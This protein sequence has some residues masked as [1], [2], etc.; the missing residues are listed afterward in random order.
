MCGFV[1]VL[2]FERRRPHARERESLLR[3]MGRRIAHRGPDDEQ[4]HDDGCLSLLFRRL[5]IVDVAGGAQPIWNEQRTLCVVVNGEVYNHLDLRATLRE[6]H[7]FQSR[8]DSEIV[9]HLFEELGVD[10]FERLEGMYA[11]AVWDVTRRR[12]VLARDRF[13]IKPLYYH[14]A[15]G[16][17]LFGSELKALLAHPDCPRELEWA[18]LWWFDFVEFSFPEVPTFVK[19]VHYLPGACYLSLAAGQAPEVRPYWSLADH[20]GSDEAPAPAAEYAERYSHAFQESVK[21]HLMS[22]VPAGV[23]LSGGVDSSMIAA[24]AARHARNAHCFTIVTEATRASGDA[25]QAVAVARALGLPVHPVDMSQEALEKS[26][27]YTLEAFESLIWSCD[28]PLYENEFLLKQQLHRH[29]RTVVPGLKVILLGQGAD[30][31]AGGYSNLIR[32][33][34]ATWPEYVDDLGRKREVQAVRVAIGRGDLVA[35]ILSREA[36]HALIPRP[37][38]PFHQEMLDRQLGLQACQLWHEDRTSMSQSIEARVPFL[39]HPLVELLA[40]VPPRLQA[41]LFWDKRIVRQA[42]AAVL[43]RPSFARRPKVPFD[44]TAR[45]DGLEH[46]MKWRLATRVFPA[47]REAYLE[48]PGSLLDRAPMLRLASYLALGEAYPAR[49]IRRQ[50]RLIFQGMALAV[51]ERF[52]REASAPTAPLHSPSPLRELAPGQPAAGRPTAR[53]PARRGG[54]RP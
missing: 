11:L 32:G 52:C 31:F 47:F 16:Q 38:A 29:A 21:A 53:R 50:L 18:G 44:H 8:S 46:R 25:A 4:L 3:A 41:R 1:G 12:L 28:E 9:V 22:D 34:P 23:F 15:G 51:F 48:Q 17:L 19:G 13:G 54:K 39:H 2:D 6:P 24:A 5:S 14:H 45:D 49:D 30:E 42:A 35:S 36:R 27:V 10:A 7:T 40:S 26:G 37:F 43:P 20:F 33:G